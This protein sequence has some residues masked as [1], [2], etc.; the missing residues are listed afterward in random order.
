[1]KVQEFIEK[2]N[3][4]TRIDIAKTLEVQQYVGI[5]LKRQMASLILDNCT[6][7]VDDEIHIDS[8]ERY[9]L[10]TIMVISMHTNLEFLDEDD[11]DHSAIDDYDALCKSGLLVKIIDT[12]KEDYASC[13]EILNMMTADKMQDNMTIEK[14]LYKFLDKIQNAVSESVNNLVEKL[15]PDNL[16][17]ALPINQTKLLDFFNSITEK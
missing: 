15:D 13:Q 11:T 2:Y 9:V 5:D 16:S 10:F 6:T 8:V 1:M 4:N 3:Q 17:G 12:F 14:K 7:I